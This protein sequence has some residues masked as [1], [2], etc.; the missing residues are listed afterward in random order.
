MI[1]IA[2]CI[3]DLVNEKESAVE[4][5]TQ[6]VVALCKKYPIYENDIIR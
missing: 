1:V 3:A 6:K 2:D 5:V 4:K